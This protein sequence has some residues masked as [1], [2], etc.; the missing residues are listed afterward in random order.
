MD[1]KSNNQPF[2]Q[3]LASA[4]RAWSN[5]GTP[6]ALHSSSDRPAKHTWAECSENPANEKKSV[7]KEQ[8]YYAHD[9]RR[10]ASDASDDD[11]EYHTDAAS[12][13][14]ESSRRSNDSYADGNYAFSITPTCCRRDKLNP[15]VRKKKRTIDMSDGSDDDGNIRNK[16][17]KNGKVKDPL[18]LTH[19][20]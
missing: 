5:S 15:P 13:D 1:K 20:E 16:T 14:G 10:P 17:D 6:C 19:S 9:N 8:A 7:K 2:D 12:N 4:G 18:N 3:K 11:D